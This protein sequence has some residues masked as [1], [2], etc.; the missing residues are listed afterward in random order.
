MVDPVVLLQKAAKSMKA[1]I[2]KH[3]HK[4]TRR[5]K[6]TMSI[7]V[8]FQKGYDPE[9]KSEPP[10]VLTTS[11]YTVYLDTDLDQWLDD[12]A[13]ELYQLIEEYEGFGSGWVIDC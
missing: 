6:F 7:H 5:L 1:I 10:V 12:A 9:E 3:L 4:H 11:P 13:N 8:I 2:I